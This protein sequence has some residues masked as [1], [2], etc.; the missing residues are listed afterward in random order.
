MCSVESGH[1]F[2]TV[3]KQYV[4][5]HSAHYFVS[6][7]LFT[8]CHKHVPRAPP[9]KSST[10]ESRRISAVQPHFLHRLCQTDHPRGQKKGSKRYKNGSITGA[11]SPW[12]AA[13]IGGQ[14][15][16]RRIRVSCSTLLSCR[17]GEIVEG[18][19]MGIVGGLI[20]VVGLR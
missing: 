3:T 7:P 6:L 2:C 18:L 4:F 15:R 13:V 1:A 14:S 10:L 9:S 20:F 5:T 12:A 16:G 8:F 17:A 11:N 19:I